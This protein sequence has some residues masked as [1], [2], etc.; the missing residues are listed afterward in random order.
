MIA[1][2]VS[3][4]VQEIFES[5]EQQAV[6]PSITTG[7]P[8]HFPESSLVYFQFVFAAITPILML[9]SVLGARSTSRRGS[10]SCCCGSRSS[11]RST[12][13]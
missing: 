10:R 3:T 9:G 11:T 7:P 12:R 4:C 5:W 6:I 13:S 1:E 8:F 2:P